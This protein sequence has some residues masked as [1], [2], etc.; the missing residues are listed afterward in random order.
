MDPSNPIPHHLLGMTY[1]DLGQ[2]AD[3]ERELK[4]AGQLRAKDESKP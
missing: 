2:S 1:R 3:A 4:L